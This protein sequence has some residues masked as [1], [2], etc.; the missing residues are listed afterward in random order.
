MYGLLVKTRF[1]VLRHSFMSPI[2]GSETYCFC[3]GRLSVN[4]SVCLSVSVC[5]KILSALGYMFF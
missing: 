1:G 2:S 4:L 3:H 5:L